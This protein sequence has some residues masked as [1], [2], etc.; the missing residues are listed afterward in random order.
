MGTQSQHF[1]YENCTNGKTTILGVGN[2]YGKE[3]PDRIKRRDVPPIKQG[4]AKESQA[5]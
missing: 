1:K 2:W 3:Y 4:K 5:L